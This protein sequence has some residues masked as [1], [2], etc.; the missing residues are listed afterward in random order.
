MAD[1][2]V[3]LRELGLES[4]EIVE[5]GR[6]DIKKAE[7]NPRVLRD[8]EKRKLR[9]GLK[10]HGL[11]APITLNKRTGNIVGGHQRLSI[12]DSLAGRADYTLT[13]AVIDVDEA[14]EKEINVLL[15][16]QQAM[17]DW[18]LEALDALLR[19]EALNIEA[20]G[21]DM[22]D[23]FQLFGE[24]PTHAA[25]SRVDELASRAR[26]IQEQYDRMLENSKN[27]HTDD[28]YVVVVFRDAADCSRFIRQFDLPD[29][30][31]QSGETIRR[32]MA[33]EGDDE[34]VVDREKTQPATH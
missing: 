12:L 20:M 6:R 22:A 26:E 31:Y 13:V 19:D 18:D 29:N 27:K 25:S 32:L 33:P 30:R 1:E 14:Q 3:S 2:A 9:A 15:N 17:G 8:D 34:A 28:Y 16:N 24:A 21:F 23:Y 5:M 7:Y 11:V 10:R 4:Y